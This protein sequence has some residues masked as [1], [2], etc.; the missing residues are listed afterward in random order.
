MTNKARGETGNLSK[1]NQC[2]QGRYMIKNRTSR[3]GGGPSHRRDEGGDLW[4]FSQELWVRTWGR[5]AKQNWSKNGG[6]GG[7]KNKGKDM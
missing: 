4:G 2:N 6:G 5:G 3:M 1:K 7:T